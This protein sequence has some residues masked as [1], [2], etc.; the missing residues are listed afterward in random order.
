MT[1][2]DPGHDIR[3]R[4]AAVM[5]AL[6]QHRGDADMQ[7][8]AVRLALVECHAHPGLRPSDVFRAGGPVLVLPADATPADTDAALCAELAAIAADADGGSP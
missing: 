7:A 4:R 2:T 3:C 6:A 1:G 8:E 5:N